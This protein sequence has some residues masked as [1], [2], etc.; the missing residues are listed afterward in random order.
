[1]PVG[2]LRALLTQAIDYAGL[3]PPASLP[4]EPAMQN[5]ASYVRDADSW[6][7]GAFILPIA[8]FEEA[9]HGL[10]Q[11]D[12][13]HRL[14]ISALGPKTDNAEAFVASLGAAIETIESFRSKSRG[15][16]S[17]EQFEMPL[18]AQ[19]DGEVLKAIRSIIVDGRL[20]TFWEAPAD[21]AERTIGLIAENNSSS[22][23]KKFGFKLRQARKN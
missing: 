18:P 5:H 8:Q 17:I 3:F 22:P 11:F 12:R 4:L 20:S 15:V 9:A 16:A 7:L 13:E 10:S 21:T 6:M 14:R 19:F 2:S 23:G 1:M